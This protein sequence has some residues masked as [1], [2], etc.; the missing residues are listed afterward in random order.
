[1]GVG[2]RLVKNDLKYAEQVFELSSDP[3]VKD[4]LGIKVD[5]IDDT[6]GFISY[7]VQKELEGKV[8]NRIILNEQ[9]EV[10]GITT[11]KHIDRGDGICH[12]GTWIGVPFWGKGY[13]EASKIEILKIA[14]NE[15]KMDY[16]FAGAKESN[17]RSR[18]AQ[19]KLAY[20]T[21]GVEKEFP[22]EQIIVEQEAKTKCVLN[23]VKREE[24]SKFLTSHII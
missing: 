11:L 4:V 9:D 20:M 17:T 8:I 10:V 13:N 7:I 22:N 18:R 1:M 24:F 23:V 2:V 12:M 19:E 15:L 3:G 5:H 6:I 16:V 21:I 14:F